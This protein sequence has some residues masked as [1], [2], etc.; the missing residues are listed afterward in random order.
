MNQKRKNKIQNHKMLKKNTKNKAKSLFKSL[1]INK[2]RLKDKKKQ[3]LQQ[4]KFNNNNNNN[5]KSNNNNKLIKNI[6]KIYYIQ[7]LK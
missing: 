7:M 6:I 5:N 3:H 2:K 1:I 4:S